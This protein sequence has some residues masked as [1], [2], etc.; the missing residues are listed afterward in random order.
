MKKIIPETWRRLFQK[1]EE[2]YSRNVKKAIP[3]NMK[4]AIPE[5]WRR[6]FHKREEG[7]SRNVK[8]VIP[9]TCRVHQDRYIRFYWKVIVKI[10]ISFKSC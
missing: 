8:K 3:R 4:K 5:T 1:R 10:A 9:E 7:Y 2:G 6:L